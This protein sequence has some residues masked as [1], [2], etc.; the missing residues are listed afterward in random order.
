MV[1]K[2]NK[3]ATGMDLNTKDW[4]T[5]DLDT[6]DSE[7][8]DF[9]GD[10]KAAKL[11]SRTPIGR[12]ASSISGTLYKAGKSVLGGAGK[13][14]ANKVRSS[15]PETDSVLSDLSEIRDTAEIIRD[16]GSKSALPLINSISKI[17]KKLIAQHSGKLPDQIEKKLMKRLDELDE[18]TASAEEHYDAAAELAKAREENLKKIMSEI[19]KA[20]TAERL[21]DKKRSAADKLIDAKLSAAQHDE[22]L[23]VLSDIRASNAF[24]SNFMRSTM[25]AYMK[26][27]IEL[28]YKRMF[29][30]EDTLSVISNLAKMQEERL[31]SIIKNTS[32][33]ET[34][35]LE[36]W[37]AIKESGKRKIAEKIT[38]LPGAIFSNVSQNLLRN[39]IAPAMEA[40]LSAASSLDMA[41]EMMGGNDNFTFGEMNPIVS[42]LLEMTGGRLGNR[43]WNK[44]KKRYDTGDRN[45]LTNNKL[46]RGIDDLRHNVKSITKNIVNHAE[47]PVDNIPIIGN[48]L[49]DLIRNNLSY[50]TFSDPKAVLE[51]HT[52][53][54]YNAAGIVTNKTIV[55]IEDIIPGYLARMDSNLEALATGKSEGM[56]FWDP[57]QKKFVTGAEVEGKIKDLMFGDKTAKAVDINN[58]IS[59]LKDFTRDYTD[60]RYNNIIR[61]KF[62]ANH[63]L[64]KDAATVLSNLA[65]NSEYREIDN[66]FVDSLN[67]VIEGKIN[68]DILAFIK[69]VFA[70][71]E[72][73]NV[74]SVAR[75]YFLSLTEA[76]STKGSYLINKSAV[77][78]LND[79]LEDKWENYRKKLVTSMKFASNLGFDS[80]LNKYGKRTQMGAL[81]FD[82]ARHQRHF[83]E[84]VNLKDLDSFNS[85][86]GNDHVLELDYNDRDTGK[87]DAINNPKYSSRI[88]FKNKMTA[89][90]WEA[91]NNRNTNIR[92]R[93]LRD[94]AGR[95]NKRGILGKVS[96]LYNQVE[97]KLIDTMVSA[98]DKY[99]GIKEAGGEID[100]ETAEKLAK[101]NREFL[102]KNKNIQ[103]LGKSVKANDKIIA[104]LR[105]KYDQSVKKIISKKPSRTTETVVHANTAISNSLESKIVSLLTDIRD[106]ML[107]F[108]GIT[109]KKQTA[110]MEK[111]VEEIKAV[112]ESNELESEEEST[113][114]E[115]KIQARRKLHQRVGDRLRKA[116]KGIFSTDTAGYRERNRLNEKGTVK[117][118]VA[119]FFTRRGAQILDTK[120]NFEFNESIMHST[121][122]V[123]L[124]DGKT[125]RYIPGKLYP[126][127]FDTIGN[128]LMVPVRF[129]KNKIVHMNQELLRYM[130]DSGKLGQYE[131]TRDKL[132]PAEI[133]S[134]RYYRRIHKYSVRDIND[135]FDYVLETPGGCTIY[136]ISEAEKAY[137]QSKKNR[138]G[139]FFNTAVLG[140][141]NAVGSL[142]TEKSHI[143]ERMVNATRRANRSVKES[144]DLQMSE[145]ER[146]ILK[147]Y[148]LAWTPKDEEGNPAINPETGKPMFP[149]FQKRKGVFGSGIRVWVKNTKGE[150]MTVSLKEFEKIRGFHIEKDKPYRM[151]SDFKEIGKQSKALDDE[152][153][154]E[155]RKMIK[156]YQEK[157]TAFMKEQGVGAFR[158]LFRTKKF[159]DASAKWR[160]QNED[161]DKEYRKKFE[162]LGTSRKLTSDIYSYA[163]N[164]F[165]NSI[166]D[167]KLI[168]EVIK[169]PKYDWMLRK[170]S[171]GIYSKQQM[172]REK[173]SVKDHYDSQWLASDPGL[174]KE[175]ANEVIALKD[176]KKKEKE[177]TAKS[178]SDLSSKALQYRKTSRGI[179]KKIIDLT[180]GIKEA[181]EKGNDVGGI[182][183][184]WNRDVIAKLSELDETHRNEFLES[185]ELK[186]FRKFIKKNYN[187]ISFDDDKL[188]LLN[189]FKKKKE[190][191]P[192]EKLTDVVE[193]IKEELTLHTRILDST[194]ID[195]QVSST[196]LAEIGNL[197][198]TR[199]YGAGGA[200]PGTPSGGTPPASNFLQNIQ[201]RRAFL[202]GNLNEGL[203]SAR[204]SAKKKLGQDDDLQQWAE[205]EAAKLEYHGADSSDPKQQEAAKERQHAFAVFLHDALR[206]HAKETGDNGSAFKKLYSDHKDDTFRNQILTEAIKQ[207]ILLPQDGGAEYTAYRDKRAKDWQRSSQ[208]TRGDQDGFFKDP[209][210]TTGSGRSEKFSGTE[211]RLRRGF[212]RVRGEVR[213][214][215]DSFKRGLK[216][217]FDA[218]KDA[219]ESA[220]PYLQSGF[221]STTSAIEGAWDKLKNRSNPHHRAANGA[222]IVDT[223][224]TLRRVGGV[225]NQPTNIAGGKIQVGE[226]GEESVI[227]HKNN[228]R[229]RNLITNAVDRTIG[230]Q[231]AKE[232]AAILGT[233]TQLANGGVVGDTLRAQ[234]ELNKSGK[235]SVF[236]ADG[237]IIS[238]LKNVG[239]AGLTLGKEA[240]G[241][242]LK[243]LGPV[244]GAVQ[245]LLSKG[246]GILNF[247]FKGLLKALN[248]GADGIKGLFEDKKKQEKKDLEEHVEGPLTKIYNALTG[249]KR[250]GS[251]EDEQERRAKN[252][253]NKKTPSATDKLIAKGGILG[254][255]FGALGNLFKG[256]KKE[257]EDGEDATSSIAKGTLIGNLFTS[258]LGKSAKAAKFGIGMLGKGIALPFR[259]IGTGTRLGS[260]LGGI[261]AGRIGARVAGT[262]ALGASTAG[263]GLLASLGAEYALEKLGEHG[264]PREKL[265]DAALYEAYGLPD[266]AR[267]VVRNALKDL[268]HD[269]WDKLVQKQI[270]PKDP[271]SVPAQWKGDRLRSFGIASEFLHSGMSN[272]DGEIDRRMEFLTRWFDQRFFPIFVRYSTFI[273]AAEQEAA[274]KGSAEKY[275]ISA[276]PDVKKIDG[277]IHKSLV[278]EFK[279]QITDVTS[280]CDKLNLGLST[281]YFSKWRLDYARE[282]LD[283]DVGK[284]NDQKLVEK[285]LKR[286]EQSRDIALHEKLLGESK[287]AFSTGTSLMKEG[288]YVS[289]L[290]EYVRGTG[291]GAAGVAAIAGSAILGVFRGLKETITGEISDASINKSAWLEA[292]RKLYGFKDN[293][294][295]K[296]GKRDDFD[297]LLDQFE[298]EEFLILNGELP[299]RDRGNLNVW[300]RRFLDFKSILLDRDYYKSEYHVDVDEDF[301][302]RFFSTWYR[303]VFGPVFTL[304]VTTCN[305]ASGRLADNT[306]RRYERPDPDFIP[307]NQRKKALQQFMNS[308]MQYLKSDKRVN[309]QCSNAGFVAWIEEGHTKEDLENKDF[310]SRKSHIALTRQQEQA[311]MTAEGNRLLTEAKAAWDARDYVTAGKKAVTGAYRA[312]VGVAQGMMEAA[313]SR[314]GSSAVKYAGTVIKFIPGLDSI[315]EEIESAG[316]GSRGPNQLIL[317]WNKLGFGMSDRIFNAFFTNGGNINKPDED[318]GKKLEEATLKFVE[319]RTTKERDTFGKLAMCRVVE[320]AYRAGMF[321]TIGV[322]KHAVHDNLGVPVS[323]IADVHDIRKLT[324]LWGGFKSQVQ[325][326]VSFVDALG[327]CVWGSWSTA[328]V[329]LVVPEGIKETPTNIRVQAEIDRQIYM[330]LKRWFYNRFVP[331]FSEWVNIVRTKTN[332]PP[333]ADFNINEVISEDTGFAAEGDAYYAVLTEFIK[334]VNALPKLED[335]L[336]YEKIK[337][338]IKRVQL[339]HGEHDFSK[340]DE[341]AAEKARKELA[342]A[343]RDMSVS[344]IREA[345][346]TD[347]R[348]VEVS[349]VHLSDE[350]RV[351][352]LELED[353][354]NKESSFNLTGSEEFRGNDKNKLDEF[355]TKIGGI[356]ASAAMRALPGWQRLLAIRL[357]A[358]GLKNLAKKLTTNGLK[359]FSDDYGAICDAEDFIYNVFIRNTPENVNI[360]NMYRSYLTSYADTESQAKA[361]AISLMIRE[362]PSLKKEY[363]AELINMKAEFGGKEGAKFGAHWGKYWAH[364]FVYRVVSILLWFAKV[365]E[366][367]KA[368]ANLFAGITPMQISRHLS[369]EQVDILFNPL[370]KEFEKILGK[371]GTKYVIDIKAARKA[372]GQRADLSSKVDDESGEAGSGPRVDKNLEELE[373]QIKNKKSLIH[374]AQE[375]GYTGVAA[376]HQKELDRISAEYDAG[377]REQWKL[378]GY[379]PVNPSAMI[380]R[381]GIEYVQGGPLATTNT[382]A[383]ASATPE[384]KM[385]SGGVILDNP[386]QVN[387]TKMLPSNMFFNTLN[388]FSISRSGKVTDLVNKLNIDNMTT[389]EL[390][391]TS[392]KLA[393]ANLAKATRGSFDGRTVSTKTTADTPETVNDNEPDWMSSITKLWSDAFPE[394]ST[395]TS[396]N[397]RSA[398]APVQRARSG[399][400]T[401]NSTAATTPA[402]AVTGNTS[403]T[404]PES[405]RTAADAASS[406]MQRSTTTASRTGT[407]VKS[408]SKRLAAKVWKF[409]TG[410][411]WTPHGVAGLLG[412]LDKESGVEAMR[413]QAMTGKEARA[414]QGDRKLSKEYTIKCDADRNCFVNPLSVGYGL[415]QWTPK[416]RKL[417]L[418]DF[419][420]SRNK[421]IADEDSQIEFLWKEFEKG[422]SKGRLH[423]GKKWLKKLKSSKNMDEAAIIVL[424]QFERPDTKE[425]PAEMQD[426]IDRA[427]KWWNILGNGK[428]DDVETEKPSEDSSATEKAIAEISGNSET[429]GSETAANAPT[430]TTEVQNAAGGE[431]A[432][433]GYDSYNDANADMFADMAEELSKPSD[434]ARAAK[435]NIKQASGFAPASQEGP[436]NPVEKPHPQKERGEKPGPEGA[437]NI[438]LK[439]NGSLDSNITKAAGNVN[440][441]GLTKDFASRLA[442]VTG[443]YKKMTGNKPVMTSAQRDD[444]YQALLWVRK[445]KFN[446]RGILAVNR[447]NKPQRVT[448]KGK[449]FDVLGGGPVNPHAQ[450]NAVDFSR[451]N[452]LKLIKQLGAKVGISQPYPKDQVHFQLAKN[453]PMFDGTD[454]ESTKESIKETEQTAIET[455]KAEKENKSSMAGSLPA[456]ALAGEDTSGTMTSESMKTGGAGGNFDGSSSIPADKSE[457][458]TETTKEPEIISTPAGSTASTVGS[459]GNG[460]VELDSTKNHSGFQTDT[461]INNTPDT[462]LEEKMMQEQTSELRSSSELLKQI[463]DILNS[464]EHKNTASNAEPAI[465]TKETNTENFGAITDAIREG[466]ISAMSSM[467]TGSQSNLPAVPRSNNQKTVGSANKT[468]EIRTP[469]SIN[470]TM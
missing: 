139:G 126:T 410:K 393:L 8:E 212:N 71:V 317:R 297:K 264:D 106:I 50:R 243:L 266:N 145:R 130:I 376:F 336:D 33:P 88:R 453:P 445:N 80:F 49:G 188:T 128:A 17:S 203:V 283:K 414:D 349:N 171:E 4:D 158:T 19:F 77:Q 287:S 60:V 427:H 222:V 380:D 189:Q 14:I 443:E 55:T 360:N 364:W 79:V 220:K 352:I 339:T 194:R 161:L 276:Y 406:T 107:K 201:E 403:R 96:G 82:T 213:S 389:D 47:N 282:E 175:I 431:S 45:L 93:W 434:K 143:K 426:R 187:S 383:A 321:T 227:P 399:T 18:K 109:I 97:D 252:K 441:A 30:A 395:S 447:P 53:N 121:P 440:T 64:Q 295:L 247:M 63:Q 448:Y 232:V 169:S 200:T 454:D 140:S 32:L 134:F 239:G 278:E 85:G 180:K 464:I 205:K 331:A 421:S 131:P 113:P 259:M 409:F 146:E 392:V 451:S 78:H 350:G 170:E 438:N 196:T 1:F 329:H 257:D 141:V 157:R 48:F 359:G 183:E 290:L 338:I 299:P 46:E 122:K 2:K 394:N 262:L 225:V 156:E 369:E 325:N 407:P 387:K 144:L 42:T 281:S 74:V 429:T 319:A 400:S 100:K 234:S 284:T 217:T 470:K 320:L 342:A 313:G 94:D 304:Y 9:I 149:F 178:A 357:N 363:G 422:D 417:E 419:C 302:V 174:V 293:P 277:Y 223:N 296:H 162:D 68:K 167:Q 233:P 298:D 206:V 378:P 315:G 12:L 463:R 191:T 291:K 292:K 423:I 388:R 437:G 208:G 230:D 84:G 226:A 326:I 466:F 207:G 86:F 256:H 415:A 424:Q 337:E 120:N 28:Q 412:N 153:Q 61:D 76:N 135:K 116:T 272:K 166:P 154:A 333:G 231:K 334:A 20:Q 57:Q 34:Q 202:A 155:R 420:H 58:D 129:G 235:P 123:Q 405:G 411:G 328:P 38:G 418:W 41:V 345:T 99:L 36:Q 224:D 147:K 7:L 370:S 164:R 39:K 267:A 92:N 372:S 51:T 54:N 286:T 176:R 289:G 373:R 25:T 444:K 254:S 184:S 358:Y 31:D 341:A 198:A 112:Q 152:F 5:F 6:W 330:Y 204:E 318:F 148:R 35:K 390:L 104:A 249:K 368:E 458:I 98:T 168:D 343:R 250:K 311:K 381:A 366:K 229:F 90:E 81:E 245:Y 312:S 280:A 22:S 37:E 314:G 182:V 23:S 433:R 29:L 181:R 103:E 260:R 324:G 335:P 115:V 355:L 285:L 3:S 430:V 362:D 118:R 467:S 209:L 10:S 327:E 173:V 353:E 159:K 275:D 89:S 413:K 379:I 21:E 151:V 449:T 221:K 40:G 179:A 69:E 87:Y 238:T 211:S 163:V 273:K 197:I 11:N 442:W 322:L 436:T 258:V 460:S 114:E 306:N 251:Y 268:Q 228:I 391:A 408:D 216:Y 279:S 384:V 240:L 66:K 265:W 13:A 215:A 83:R 385:A 165:E 241:A 396:G 218:T 117:E 177:T 263:V 195:T 365:M 44:F 132:I 456:A 452:N 316:K 142:F 125:G 133:K 43:L 346:N 305:T 465:A 102:S 382:Q 24:Q 62:V 186:E 469:I 439:S 462:H 402:G 309:L 455:I 270:D 294:A 361:I 185:D 59:T 416:A 248:L 354:K 308:G 214:T 310:D 244:G 450:G 344:E 377:K 56:R 271:N 137:E 236:M 288:K 253:K 457:L 397:T 425:S 307:A 15:F 332:T 428:A 398:T 190:K 75:F 138:K 27:T 26:K 401:Y 119:A 136:R 468:R 274:K 367:A 70:G 124:V 72:P 356:R 347:A 404:V 348:K 435:N 172:S 300:A 459:T 192:L 110:T 91:L 160:A 375:R 261:L 150:Y 246:A 269:I 255:M 374:T 242:G 73:D 52:L 193:K 351:A 67:A 219:A 301:I 95:I 16:E 210:N 371:E 108:S 199:S 323:K 65:L 432:A 386:A 111:V 105:V 101:F 446:D 127:E 461:K 340:M 303:R 237:G